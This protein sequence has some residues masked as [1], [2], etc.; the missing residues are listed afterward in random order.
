MSLYAIGPNGMRVA[1]R[2]ACDVSAVRVVPGQN[3]DSSVRYPALVADVVQALDFLY[4][5]VDVLP[6]GTAPQVIGG[7]ALQGFAAMVDM[8]N[9]LDI[10]PDDLAVEVRVGEEPGIAWL[11]LSLGGTV[12]CSVRWL[13]RSAFGGRVCRSFGWLLRYGLRTPVNSGF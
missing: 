1:V 9:R 6:A 3:Q 12:R 10:S 7:N 8:P 13:V 5:P 4:V 11:R 2:I